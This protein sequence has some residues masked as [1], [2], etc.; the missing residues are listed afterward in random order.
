MQAYPRESLMGLVLMILG[1]PFYWHW[2]RRAAARAPTE[3]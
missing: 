1:V 2:K 3:G